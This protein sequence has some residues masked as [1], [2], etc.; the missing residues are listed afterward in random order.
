MLQANYWRFSRKGLLVSLWLVALAIGFMVYGASGHDDPHINFRFAYTLLE[1]GELLNYNGEH[2]GQ[3]TNLL[4]VFIMAFFHRI[5]PFDLIT[6]GYLVDVVACLSCCG[7]LTYLA[8]NL[9]PVVVVWPALLSLSCTAFIVWTFGGMGAV[10]ASFC[11]LLSAAV[12]W[13]FIESSPLSLGHYGLLVLTALATVLVRPEMPFLL[14]AISGYVLFLHYLDRVKRQRCWKILMVN[15]LAGVL[16]LVWHKMYFSSWLPMPVL[17]KQTGVF[18]S[19]ARN[20]FFY[21]LIYSILNPVVAVAFFCAVFL[22]LR[23]LW[24]MSLRGVTSRDSAWIVLSAILLGYWGFVWTS[25]GDWMPAGRFIVPVIPVA[26]LLVT[27]VLLAWL[28]G[29]WL[30]HGVLALLVAV[31]L[32]LHPPSFVNGASGVPVWARYRMLHEHENQYSVFE[33]YNYEHLRDMAVID[34]F[35]EI[36]PPLYAKLKRPVRLISGQSGMVFYTLAAKFPGMVQFT[37][38]R[39]LVEG[40]LTQCSLLTHMQRDRYGLGW[41]GY[42]E[43]FKRLPA[44]QQTCGVLPPDIAF[45]MDGIFKDTDAAFFAAG[46]SKIHKEQGALIDVE[47]LPL[48]AGNYNILLNTMFIRSDLL[49]YVP[50]ASVR[51]IDYSTMPLHERWGYDWFQRLTQMWNGLF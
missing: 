42:G 32:G 44:L 14:P 45:E 33:K 46:Y 28:R 40:S 25:G 16:L 48:P 3:S 8:R 13:R 36:I 9:C 6:C 2:V 22:S 50:D 31:T 10:L 49:P 27:S 11:L 1:R 24:R 43:Y 35:S 41:Q 23:G 20:G 34:H 37:D 19:E 29:S 51:V 47:G 15:T 38:L 18:L 12:W 7:L 5:L 17:A 30:V 21:V 39:G 4:L 26:A